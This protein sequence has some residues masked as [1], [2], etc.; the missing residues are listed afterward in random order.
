MKR[1]DFVLSGL[2]AAAATRA[3]SAAPAPAP[4]AATPAAPAPPAAAAV[5]GER[6]AMLI[7]GK[8]SLRQR[9]LARPSAAVRP[10]VG[11]ANRGEALQAMTPLFVFDRKHAGDGAEWVEIGRSDHGQTLG[12]LPAAEVIEWPHTMTAVF[13]NPTGRALTMFFRDRAPLV[14]MLAGNNIANEV[15][16]YAERAAHP[17]VPG[18]FPVIAMEPRHYVDPNLQFYLLPILQAERLTFQDGRAFKVLEIASI[19]LRQTPPPNAGPFTLNVAF[20]MDT[21]LSMDPYIERVR[22]ALNKMVRQI[23]AAA[24]F[25]A[26]F[27]LMGFRNSL[28]A[29]PRLEYLNKIFV[30]FGDNA[31][32]AAFARE[33]AAVKATNVDSLSFDE[34]SFAAVKAA[35]TDLDWGDAGGKVLILVTDS[36]SRTDRFSATHLD[37]A[38]LRQLAADQHVPIMV[39]HLRTPAGVADHAFAEGQYV[40]LSKYGNLDP[41]YFP[42]RDGDVDELNRTVD[43]IMPRLQAVAHQAADAAQPPRPAGPADIEGRVDMLGY[44]LLVEWLGRQDQSRVPEVVRG[45]VT[46]TYGDSNH[47]PVPLNLEVRV[48][49]T[50]NQINDLD[51]ALGH[52]IEEGRANML[53]SNMVF[54]RLQTVAAR[55]ARDPDEISRHGLQT[56][57][58]LMGEYLDDLPYVSMIAGYDRDSWRHLGP[59]RQNQILD[60]LETRRRLYREFHRTPNLWVSFDGGRDPGEAMYRV[61]LDLLP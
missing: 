23:A 25:R 36:G 13:T 11:A 20:L 21:T 60:T 18:D 4:P 14:S 33:L 58:D 40:T 16:G 8:R 10:A 26:R 32:P 2:T 35:I 9:V 53:D 7:P 29:Q 28:A 37:A 24:D 3:S 50:R 44:A 22:D 5:A 41:L 52:I 51:E 27:A 54:E 15:H 19:P 30:R 6:R 49:L 39:L 46:D 45:W 47:P 42:V 17:P 55:V 57:G 61:P 48:L 12:W 34:D 31:D 1:R 59:S 38:A 43:R 56:L